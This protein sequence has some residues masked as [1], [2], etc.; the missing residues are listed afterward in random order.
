MAQLPPFPA[1]AQLPSW[2]IFHSLSAGP[3]RSHVNALSPL[4]REGSLTV[5]PTPCVADVAAPPVSSISSYLATSPSWTLPAAS[6][7][8]GRA[9]SAIALRRKSPRP[10]NSEPPRLCLPNPSSRVASDLAETPNSPELASAAVEVSPRSQSSAAA[11]VTIVGSHHLVVV[12]LPDPFYCFSLLSGLLTPSP[13]LAGSRRPPRQAPRG[14]HDLTADLKS[15]GEFS[16]VP[17]TSLF[18]SH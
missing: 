3:G 4:P 14:C 2:P 6:S 17:S 16:I 15:L 5:R 10:I 11:A 13:N 7:V 9:E 8:R 1:S 12:D 18:F